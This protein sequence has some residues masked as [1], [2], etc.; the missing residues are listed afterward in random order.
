METREAKSFGIIP[1]FKNGGEFKTIIVK[2]KNGDHWG[3]PKGTPE[4]SETAIETAKRELMEET[5]IVN[6]DIRED[7][8]FLEKYPFEREGTMYN[9]T[10]LYYLGF[11]NEMLIGE[12][13][14]EIAEVKWVSFDEAKEVLTHQTAKDVMSEVEKFLINN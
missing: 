10:N 14:D 4:G 13:S 7:K 2:N 1:I 11:V 6:V 8:T 9:K 12:Y 3:S 5:G